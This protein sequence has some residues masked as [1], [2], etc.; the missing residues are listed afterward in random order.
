[1]ANVITGRQWTLD[2][3]GV[4]V[5]IYDHEIKV[6]FIEL[7]NYIAA[8]DA[9]IVKDRNG[10]VVWTA[11]GATDF[12]EVRSGDIGWVDGLIL[13]RLDSGVCRVYIQ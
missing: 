13:E 11:V 10:R 8:G 6:K 9:V 5:I 3:P 12:S 7:A 1:V 4:G 2:T